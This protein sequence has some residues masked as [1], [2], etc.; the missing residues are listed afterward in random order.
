MAGA[1]AVAAWEEV[2]TA[3][4]AWVASRVVVVPVVVAT[5]VAMEAG[6]MVVVG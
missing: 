3:M 6:G 4:V 1:T 5:A 2:G